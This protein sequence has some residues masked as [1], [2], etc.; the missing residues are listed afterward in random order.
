MARFNNVEVV[1]V[2][3]MLRKANYANGEEDWMLSVKKNV[4]DLIVYYLFVEGY[5]QE[6]NRD[7]KESNVNNLVYV[8]ISPVVADFKRKTGAEEYAAV[9]REGD[10]FTGL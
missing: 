9:E 4:Y 6:D 2:E 5:P 3:D 10:H 8:T 1:S 7:F